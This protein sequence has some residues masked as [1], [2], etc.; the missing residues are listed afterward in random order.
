MNLIDGSEERT[1]FYLNV[2][3]FGLLDILVYKLFTKSD[4]K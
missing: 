2:I 4:K 1:Y 3:S